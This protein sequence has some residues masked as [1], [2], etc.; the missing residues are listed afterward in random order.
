MKNTFRALWQQNRLKILNRTGTTNRVSQTAVSRRRLGRAAAV[1]MLTVGL[2]LICAAHSAA[3]PPGC[4]NCDYRRPITIDFANLGGSC[5]ADL[6]GFPVLVSIEGAAYLKNDLLD[7]KVEDLM[8]RDIAFT[9][10]VGTPLNHEVELYNP[11]TG[12]LAAWVNVPT[13]SAG[14]NT[15]IY[16]YYGDSGVSAPTERPSDV[17]DG[18]YLGV[19]HLNQ[20]PTGA[21]GDIEDSTANANHGQSVNMAAGDRTEDGRIG[22]ALEFDGITDYV[23]L[24]DLEIHNNDRYTVSVWL[25]GPAGQSDKRFFAEASTSNN[26]PLF[27][28]GTDNSGTTGKADLYVRDNNGQT[29][30]NHAKTNDAVF[31]DTWH[32]V[33]F[34]DDGGS[35][36]CYVDGVASLSGTYNPKQQKDFHTTSLGAIARAAVSHY[37][38]ATIDEVRVSDTL[39]DAC[40]IETEYINQSNPSG[41]YTFGN[42]E[43]TNPV[44]NTYTITA[45]VDACCVDYGS[46]APSGAV[47]VDEGDPRIFYLLAESGYE[48]D[49]VIIDGDAQDWDSDQYTFTD[50]DNNHTIAVKF[51][52]ATD[53]PPGDDE[54]LPPGCLEN[55]TADYSS[56]FAPDDLDLVNCEVDANGYVTLNTGNVAVDTDNIVLPFRQQVA[57]T[58]MYEKGNH[59]QS[60]FGYMLGH[61]DPDANPAPQRIVYQNINDN[62]NNGV[63]DVSGNS[64]NDRFG[65]TNGDGVVNVLDNRVVLGIFDAGTELV[66]FLK[67]DDEEYRDEEENPVTGEDVTDFADENDKV[68]HYTKTAWNQSRFTSRETISRPEWSCERAWGDPFEKTYKL[69]EA[70]VASGACMQND[71]WMDAD[72]LARIAAPF[73]LYFDAGDTA[74]LSFDWD[75][76]WPA[77]MAGAPANNLNAWV[78]GFE[79]IVGGGDADHNDLIFIIERETGGT[80]KLKPAKAETPDDPDAHIR[81]V[82]LGVWDYM[83]SG[84]CA[85]LTEITYFLSIDAGDNWVEVNGWDEV[86]TFTLIDGH[87]IIG[88]PVANWSTG[89]PAYTHRTRRVDFAGLGYS[90]RELIWRAALKSRKEGCEPAIMDMTLDMTVAV[91][92]HIARATPALLANVMY[93]T[94]METPASDWTSTEL[95]GHLKATRIYDPT[96]PD[97]TATQDLWDAG[98][99]LK[100]QME[101]SGRTIYIPDVTVLTVDGGSAELLATGDGT[102]TSFQGVLAQYPVLATTV[103]IGDTYETFSDQ[104][105]D[106]LEGSLGGSGWINRFTGEYRMTFTNPPHP[107]QPITATYSYFIY[108]PGGTLREFK[109]NNV[110]AAELG[111]D[112]STVIPS[113]Y[114]Y[115]LDDDDDFDA[116]DAN[117]LVNWTR[118]YRDGNAKLAEKQWT[119]GALDHSVPAVATPPAPGTWYYGSAFPEDTPDSANDRAGYRAFKEAQTGRRTVVY[120][121]AR[122]GMLHAFDAGDFRWGDNPCTEE[123]EKRGYFRWTDPGDPNPAACAAACPAGCQPYYGIGEELWAFIPANLLPR[124]KNNLLQGDDKAYVDA[125]PALADVYTDG[126]WRT[127]LLS[128][129]GNGGDTIYCLDVT[130][131]DAP[132]FMWEFADPDLFR[133]RSSPAVT[134][135]GRIYYEGSAKWVAFFVSGKT[136]DDTLYPSIYVIDIAD[137]SPVAKISLDAASDGAGGVLSGQPAIVDSDGNGYVDR[138]YIGSDKG[139]L[140]KV[141]LPDS[142]ESL[143]F[144]IGHCVVNTDFSDRDGDTVS[145]D[146]RYQPIY[147]SP[148]VVSSI[149]VDS[150]GTLHYDIRIFFGTG[151]SPYYDEDIDFGNTRYHFYAYRD[152]TA[153]GQCNPSGVTLDWFKELDAGHR[154]YT[155]AF[156]AAGNIYFG[157]STGETEDPCDLNANGGNGFDANAGILYVYD[158]DNPDDTPIREIQVGNVLAS[159]VVADRHVYVQSVSGTIDSFGDGKYNNAIR[160]GGIPE[161]DISWW[162]EMF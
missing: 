2:S 30:V 109:E 161:I 146:W 6:T 87:K 50:V 57:V 66:F 133:S 93:S 81:G 156:A 64:T 160:L 55:E 131:P 36:T 74:S 98:A 144:A 103:S 155:S 52:E 20:A 105:T 158:M 13:L 85:G 27:N 119:L 86:Y 8:G 137:G 3:A 72:A 53:D 140:Y 26:R 14:T 118:G 60:D 102:T 99:V 19:W 96:D 148:A 88:D 7:G 116:A 127:V 47:E 154:I 69:G 106:E 48:V 142:P 114:I 150:T 108:N 135:I 34:V 157:T 110:L 107:G 11:N 145:A 126:A 111:M 4:P 141:N 38:E 35:Y 39:R 79:D 94:S 70:Q 59:T 44:V 17:W 125:S 83:P 43:A 56:G 149:S 5:G 16:M 18:N 61:E 49:Q 73:N 136:Y 63:L 10:D 45:S 78:L 33:D 54:D 123:V 25:R 28:L 122:D 162:R 29:R 120:V 65:D 77:V 130:D 42:E 76:R 23:L 37:I 117:W 112:D 139:L 51:K 22:D 9:D 113:G 138:L 21:D 58:F 67:P 24:G 151:D 153:K 80:A 147:G 89:T 143:K 46:I 1:L 40:W 97:E 91:P 62:N 121:G 159:P 75:D 95:R 82:T 100:N 132:K 15:V 101:P 68:Y 32:R 104:H 31:D 12:T 134:Q 92:G 90:G 152:T 41:F 124:L 71:G 84:A 129:E 115:D 128:A